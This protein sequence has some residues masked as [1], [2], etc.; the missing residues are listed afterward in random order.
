MELFLNPSPINPGLGIDTKGKIL[1]IFNRSEL[2]FI[3]VRA[4]HFHLHF[5]DSYCFCI[6]YTHNEK[7]YHS[8]VRQE[9][10]QQALAAINL[11]KQANNGLD[12]PMPSK[13]ISVMQRSSANN[14]DVSNVLH[15]ILV[16]AN[17]ACVI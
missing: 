10:V 9:A 6:R 11:E 14:N 4:L 12:V 5:S 2:S 15:S 7:R 3:L 13:R 17:F 8:E 16:L 1:A